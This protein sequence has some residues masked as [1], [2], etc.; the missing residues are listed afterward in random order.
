MGVVASLTLGPRTA[1]QP[2]ASAT[3]ETELE[4]SLQTPDPSDAQ[5]ERE[6]A[7]LSEAARQAGETVPRSPTSEGSPAPVV[8]QSHL[9]G[10]RGYDYRALEADFIRALQFTDD[11][12]RRRKL[13]EYATFLAE[14]DPEMAV[15]FMRTILETRDRLTDRDAYAFATI[16]VERYAQRDPAAAAAWTDF[17]PER[18]KF[19]THQLL[20]REWAAQDPFA[21]DAWIR[22]VDH[23][24]LRAS[25]IRMMSH[26][27]T[28]GEDQQFAAQWGQALSQRA[29]DAS[30]LSDVVVQHW[31]AV[32]FD[33][34]YSWA[35][36]LQNA[37]DREQGLVTLVKARARDDAPGAADWSRDTLRGE[38][39]T[40]GIHEAVVA[41]VEKD[42]PAV[43]RWV[44]QLGDQAIADSTFDMI[45]IAWA[46][47]DAASA[48]QWIASAPV[49][50]HR[51]EYVQRMARQ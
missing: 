21:A 17:L 4:R 22:S 3:G 29:D 24:G 25:A 9:S 47:K 34:A 32:D 26:T 38:V 43:A 45:A 20:V 33:A 11:E 51:K 18:L 6:I 50:E 28:A 13:H 35:A 14:K 48:A 44:G 39:R 49:A 37:D 16:F 41:W 31:G 5:L 23:A 15:H 19:P 46:K 42:P 2:E 1:S 7:L 8:P 36:S 30:R 10:D 27:L 40:K 12:A